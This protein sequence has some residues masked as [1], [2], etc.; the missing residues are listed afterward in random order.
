MRNAINL[1]SLSVVEGLSLNCRFQKPCLSFVTYCPNDI[2]QSLSLP[3]LWKVFYM[4][5]EQQNR[6]K[7]EKWPNEGG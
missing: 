7:Q 3:H 1:L 4:G 2:E 5:L 6:K